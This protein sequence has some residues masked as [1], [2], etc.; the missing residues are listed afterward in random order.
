M[1]TVVKTIVPGELLPRGPRY[2]ARCLGCPWASASTAIYQ[3]IIERIAEEHA[4]LESHT[5]VIERVEG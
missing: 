1:R 2:G 4:R 3:D 5:V